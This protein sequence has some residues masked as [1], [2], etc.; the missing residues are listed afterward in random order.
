M[1]AG[2]RQNDIIDLREKGKAEINDLLFFSV[3]KEV[4]I[5]RWPQEQRGE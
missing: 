3:L 5:G 2:E 1:L 4:K